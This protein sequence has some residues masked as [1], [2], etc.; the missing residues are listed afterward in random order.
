MDAFKIVLRYVC[1]ILL[2]LIL[3]ALHLDSYPMTNGMTMDRL[4]TKRI[5]NKAKKGISPVVATVILVAVA[6]VIAAA[7][8][9]FASS[10]FGT[11]SSSGS[12]AVKSMTV[13]VAGDGLIELVN[14]GAL[15]DSV[16]SIH[17]PGQATNGTRIALLPGAGFSNIYAMDLAAGDCSTP[18]TPPDPAIA[19]NSEAIICFLDVDTEP[20]VDGFIAGQQM[21]VKIKMTSGA[22]LTQ[23]VTVLPAT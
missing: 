15:S 4:E 10:L 8:A 14:R 11:Y 2:V 17:V 18:A 13:N 7:L 23:S 5:N 21:T 12:I 3:I 16:A 9:G 19:A 20:N 22:E 1:N 6:V